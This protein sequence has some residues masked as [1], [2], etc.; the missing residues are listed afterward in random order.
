MRKGAPISNTTPPRG[1]KGELLPPR[2]SSIKIEECE[3]EDC[4]HKDEDNGNKT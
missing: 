2:G 4:K 1:V 3:K